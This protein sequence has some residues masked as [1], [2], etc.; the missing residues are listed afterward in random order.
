[1]DSLNSVWTHSSV[2][3]GV[4]GRMIYILKINPNIV[5]IRTYQQLHVPF[6]QTQ[7]IKVKKPNN[8]LD[9]EDSNA[10]ANVGK[11]REV[12]KPEEPRKAN[13]LHA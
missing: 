12:T 5:F 4:S 9:N 6:F 7:N 10:K 8:S 11:I 1:M 3:W 2:A 13:S